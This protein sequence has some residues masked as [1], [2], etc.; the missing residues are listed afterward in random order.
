MGHG[1][2][3]FGAGEEGDDFFYGAVAEA[4]FFGAEVVLRHESISLPNCR[5]PRNQLITLRWL[6]RHHSQIVII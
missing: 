5:L 2:D 1:E 4:E 3:I 6:L